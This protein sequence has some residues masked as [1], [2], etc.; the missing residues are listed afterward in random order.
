MRY[1]PNG[2]TIAVMILLI[3][4]LLL[5]VKSPRAETGEKPYKMICQGVR[6]D[7][8][9]GK[10][11][12]DVEQYEDLLQQISTMQPQIILIV[13]LAGVGGSVETLNRLSSAFH[14]TRAQVYGMVEGD[15]ASA[16]AMLA[17][18]LR[19]KLYANPFLI[20]L[21]HKPALENGKTIA[22][23]CEKYLNL[24]DRGL[25]LKDKCIKELSKQLEVATE[26][27]IQEVKEFLTP[28]E[29]EQL[30]QGYDILKTAKELN[31]PGLQ[32]L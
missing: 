9:L 19:P 8:F 11:I 20:F 27:I 16:H 7:L 21:F 6:C 26:E 10:K 14:A 22:Q 3:V 31:I 30:R 32:P 25:S 13:H 23:A 24:K 18:K 15:V 2:Q 5:T 1:N 28:Q 12:E 17:M 4:V 29:Q